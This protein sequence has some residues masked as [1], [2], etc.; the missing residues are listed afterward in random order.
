[1]PRA[2][3]VAE[4]MGAR[5]PGAR[6]CRCNPQPLTQGGTKPAPL[7]AQGPVR[8]CQSLRLGTSAT[9][10]GR[11]PPTREH[12]APDHRVGQQQRPPQERTGRPRPEGVPQLC[13]RVRA[14]KLGHLLPLFDPEA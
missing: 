8:L 3:R 13:P 7:A 4:R 6:G 11:Q 10:G 12:R 2:E 14:A 9:S 1:M 5:A